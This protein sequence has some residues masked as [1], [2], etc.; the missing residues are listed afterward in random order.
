MENLRKGSICHLQ[1]PCGASV[2]FLKKADGTLQLC[3]DYRGLNKI[4]IKN[5]YLWPLIGEVLERISKAKYFTKFDVQDRYNC[6]RIASCEKQKMVFQYHYGVL[7]YTVMPF[8][9][10]NNSGTFQHYMNDTFYDFLDEFLVMYLD[11]TLIYSDN[12]K[13][14]QKHMPKVLE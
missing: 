8:G 4:T 12:L 11:D 5:R 9:L 14:Y 10:Y 1:S 6:L 2:V 7:E 3:M 13:K